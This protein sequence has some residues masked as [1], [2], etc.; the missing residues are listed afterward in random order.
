M[1]GV[2]NLPD[3]REVEMVNPLLLADELPFALRDGLMLLFKIEAFARRVGEGSGPG[4]R[5]EVGARGVLGAVTEDP[6][7]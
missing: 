1:A 7:G 4:E 2:V 3:I 6:L 5:E